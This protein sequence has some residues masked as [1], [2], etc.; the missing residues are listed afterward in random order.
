M[1]SGN[2]QITVKVVGVRQA[3]RTLV[4]LTLMCMLLD[5]F[6]RP[7]HARLA[8]IPATW[9]KARAYLRDTSVVGIGALWLAT[10]TVARLVWGR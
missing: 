4:R 2:V 6:S 10:W 7:L 8:L 3:I 5:A 1:A 9:T